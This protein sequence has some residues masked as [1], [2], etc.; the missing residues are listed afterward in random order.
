M[1]DC[2]VDGT[3]DF[4]YGAGIALFENCIIRNR[5]D[6]HITASS[7]KVGKSKF[8]FDVSGRYNDVSG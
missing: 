5:K 6:S 8:G 7:H 2:I 4:I 3:S 1:K